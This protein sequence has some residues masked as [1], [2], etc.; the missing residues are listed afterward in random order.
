MIPKMLIKVLIQVSQIETDI[1]WPVNN[2]Q[3]AKWFNTVCLLSYDL[4]FDYFKVMAKETQV[5]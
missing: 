3:C 2:F 1:F 4:N 5:N